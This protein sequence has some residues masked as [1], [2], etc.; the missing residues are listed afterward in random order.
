MSDVACPSGASCRVQSALG[1]ALALGLGACRGCRTDDQVLAYDDLAEFASCE[2]V[3]VYLDNDG[4]GYGDP[5][6]PVR[7][8]EPPGP[9]VDNALDCDD[10]DASVNPA[11]TGICADSVDNDCDGQGECAALEFRNQIDGATAVMA[12]AFETAAG[13][14]M[15]VADMTGDGR[16]DY[17]IGSPD[18]EEGDTHGRVYLVPGPVSGFIDLSSP[19]IAD[20]SLDG[21][22]EEGSWIG[23]GDLDGDGQ[24]DFQLGT[25]SWY[26]YQNLII[27]VPGPLDA[28][29][30]YVID[31]E[32]EVLAW[33]GTADDSPGVSYVLIA[34]VVGGDGQDDVIFQRKLP[35]DDVEALIIPGPVSGGDARELASTALSVPSD[36]EHYRMDVIAPVG[37]IDGDGVDDLGARSGY[38]GY[39]ILDLVEGSALIADLA[40][41]TLDMSSGYVCDQ[42]MSPGDLDG[43]GLDD[44]IWAESDP[45]DVY[46]GIGNL[47][48]VFTAATLNAVSGEVIDPVASA[49]AYIEPGD[50]QFGMGLAAPG[51]FDADGYDDLFVGDP[52]AP[53]GD[54][55]GGGDASLWYGPLE[56]VLD[57]DSS[58]AGAKF[59]GDTDGS[60]FGWRVAASPRDELNDAVFLV[61]AWPISGVST[62]YQFTPGGF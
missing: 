8:C 58:D 60:R 10:D 32:P 3:T 41:V 6:Q 27:L 48:L 34:D 18:A 40:E 52:E 20:I 25:G 47:I 16:A 59:F 62:I 22:D 23:A 37:D 51:D 45:H 61:S 2:E 43:D 55:F 39:L 31:D 5:D 26:S 7:S 29:T 1:L 42:L 21:V 50:G 46:F 54:A 12:D 33:S 24:R 4:D 30:D 35:L 13:V 44:L 15:I 19:T 36:E 9:A 49:D 11:A 14:A 56:G 28:A 17:L 53:A 57:P 38:D